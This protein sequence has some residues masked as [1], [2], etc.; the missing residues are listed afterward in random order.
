MAGDQMSP[1]SD[2]VA[3]TTITCKGLAN[4]AEACPLSLDVAQAVSSLSRTREQLA[5]PFEYVD[6]W[7]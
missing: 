6:D 1:T 4:L 7:M 5:S 3:C 2:S